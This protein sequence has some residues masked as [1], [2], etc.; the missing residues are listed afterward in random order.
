[1]AVARHPEDGCRGGRQRLVVPIP[2][3]ARAQVTSACFPSHRMARRVLDDRDYD[4]RRIEG[5]TPGAC[6]MTHESET[7][8]KPGGAERL[9][10]VLPRSRL[11]AALFIHISTPGQGSRSCFKQLANEM[12]RA[13]LL[14]K[15]TSRPGDVGDR[16][17]WCRVAFWRSELRVV[18]RL[19]G[20][21]EAGSSGA[22]TTERFRRT[23]QDPRRRGWD[24]S[25]ETR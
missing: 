4:G 17:S 24:P 9:A 15:S 20:D 18:A 16:Q 11:G 3:R 21:F 6:P 8:P 2:N 13:I 19:A 1:V 22:R 23:T 7:I 12:L 10:R 5:G 14:G 25:S